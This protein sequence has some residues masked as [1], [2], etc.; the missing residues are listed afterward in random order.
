MEARAACGI[1][2]GVAQRELVPW[3]SSSSSSHGQSRLSSLSKSPC[4]SRRTSSHVLQE[5]FYFACLEVKRTLILRDSAA[6][7]RH[8]PD[9][10]TCSILDLVRPKSHLTSTPPWGNKETHDCYLHCPFLLQSETPNLSRIL[11]CFNPVRPG[12]RLLSPKISK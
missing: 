9:F 8:K 1:A 4:K 2:R 12:N 5:S 11:C 3:Q 10:V 6:A 7:Q